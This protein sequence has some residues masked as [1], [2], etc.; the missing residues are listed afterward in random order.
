MSTATTSF[1]GDVDVFEALDRLA[2][3]LEENDES[4]IS[5]QIEALDG[6]MQQ[7]LNARTQVGANLNRLE[8]AQN[9]W[10]NYTFNLE[11]LRSATEEA[12]IA[13]AYTDLT[14]QEAAYE[15]TLQAAASIVQPSLMDYV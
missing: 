1:A 6:A 5:D 7:V 10:S 13:R 12:D 3:G 15:A 9:Y 4:V 11:T 14:T 2:E 8:T